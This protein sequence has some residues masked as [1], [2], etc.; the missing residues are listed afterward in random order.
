M[1]ATLNGGGR[2]ER[3]QREAVDCLDLRAA[4]TVLEVGC[5][6]PVAT[7]LIAERIWPGGR[8]VCVVDEEVLPRVRDLT[9]GYEKV[10]L[11]E[12]P[13]ERADLPHGL[14]AALFSGGE[15]L[16]RSEPAVVSAVRRLHLG[17]RVAA[18]GASC[19]PIRGSDPPWGILERYLPHLTVRRRALTGAYV[20]CGTLERAPAAA[21]LV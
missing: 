19:L 7:A 2:C 13:V 15:E 17:A 5:R 9:E 12:G 16:L 18:F 4:D 3:T 20:A 10:T 21:G 6:S 1:G 11:V 14:D 8:I